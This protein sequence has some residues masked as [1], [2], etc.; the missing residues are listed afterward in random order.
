MNQRCALVL[1]PS[2]E[3]WFLP[4]LLAQA[5]WTCEVVSLSKVYALSAH[6]R[7]LHHVEQV[8][9]L[10]E[11][12]L[13]VLQAGLAD[14]WVIVASDELLAELRQR[15][16]L[17]RRYLAL[18]PLAGSHGLPHLFSKLHL[19]RI[20]DRYGLATPA[21]RMA[22]SAAEALQAAEMI[23]YPCFLKRD[24]SNG[25]RGVVR[26]LGPDDLNRQGLLWSA[27]P[28][29]VQQELKGQLWGVEALFWGG[30]LQAYAASESLQE[31]HTFGPSLRRRYGSLGQERQEME[32]LLMQLG[33]ALSAHGWANISLI[34]TAARGWHCFEADLRPTVWLALDQ[35]L[36]GDFAAVIAS[37]PQQLLPSP[38]LCYCSDE[39]EL[40]HPQ[41]LL[42]IDADSQRIRQAWAL[43]PDEAEVY[44]DDLREER[45]S[46]LLA[47]P[48]PD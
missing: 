13:E 17:D 38:R 2:S 35:A 12:A 1:S 10:A 19:S 44:L 43:M 16:L 15:A 3:G 32:Q 27:E 34:Q 26:C 5:G 24:A 8:E 30:R 41:R 21:W 7:R 22:N 37:L 31:M 45:F 18:L 46:A 39:R 4:S 47:A 48:L 11:Q 23:G 36:G 9:R 42:Q 33:A 25:G 20:L 40:E 14:A 29:L 28:L 6:V